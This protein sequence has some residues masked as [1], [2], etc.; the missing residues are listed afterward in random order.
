VVVVAVTHQEPLEQVER[1][2]AALVGLTQMEG[3]LEL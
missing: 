3:L 1:V 2:A